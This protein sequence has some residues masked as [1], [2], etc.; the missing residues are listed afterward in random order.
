MR[1]LPQCLCSCP[2]HTNVTCTAMSEISPAQHIIKAE[3]I[4]YTPPLSPLPAPGSVAQPGSAR[5]Q[6]SP[7]LSMAPEEAG[8]IPLNLAAHPFV[9]SKDDVA[10]WLRWAEEEFSLRAVDSGQF[11]MNGKALCLLTK[12]DFRYRSASAG[13]VLYELLQR[14]LTKSKCQPW[15]TL[16]LCFTDS[17]PQPSQRFIVLKDS[18]VGTPR[19]SPQHRAASNGTG[20]GG[21][22]AAGAAGAAGA[23]AGATGETPRASPDD[24][25]TRAP[26]QPSSHRDGN[27]RPVAVSPPRPDP[28]PLQLHLHQNHHHQQQQLYQ[29]QHHYQQQQQQ[30]LLGPVHAVRFAGAGSEEQ[31]LNLSHQ[32][33]EASSSDQPIGRIADCRLLWDYVYHLLSDYRYES[34]IRWEDRELRVFRIVEPNGLAKLWGMHKNRVNMTYEKMSRALRHYYKL[35]IIKKEPGQKLLFRFLKSPEEIVQSKTDKLER[36]EACEADGAAFKD[37]G[38]W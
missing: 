35:N 12:D 3:G 2:R 16:Q 33:Q 21:G 38:D 23:A 13:D 20:G 30:R 8:R 31:P 34:Y 5:A 26:P 28:H 10:Q 36:M 9:W 4:S 25:V 17:S 24:A 7:R 19:P 6:P 11:E 37:E 1:R 22:D 15:S 32:P 29:Q 14:I 27:C 18:P